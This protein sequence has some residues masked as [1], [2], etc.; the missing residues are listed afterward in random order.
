[1]GKVDFYFNSMIE[2]LKDKKMKKTIA[3]FWH[4]DF[5]DY[6]T[7]LNSI[8]EKIDSGNAPGKYLKQLLLL[9]EKIISKAGSLENKIKNYTILEKI[10]RNFRGAC[11]PI[12]YRSIILKRAYEKPC[13]YPGDWKMLEMIYDNVPVSSGIGSLI[14]RYF[15]L[16]PYTKAVRNRKDKIKNIL[17]EYIRGLTEREANILNIAC[18]SCR[19]IREIIKAEPQIFRNKHIVLS[20]VDQDKRA[21]KFS[22][23]EIAKLKIKTFPH[24]ILQYFINEQKYKK[25]LGK[26]NLVYSIGLADYLPDGLLKK[27]INFLF[28]LL[29]EGGR[30]IIAHKDIDEYKPVSPDWWCN[31]KF[32][33]RNEQKFIELI[34]GSNISNYKISICR[35]KSRVIFFATIRK[36]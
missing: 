11:S 33:P 12:I 26:Q 36:R 28:S 3:A 27:M 13:G 5:K 7:R 30:L 25:S 16:N 10:K 17:T 23:E 21:L 2:G 15:L 29:K 31:W 1:M 24:N 20:L 35:E 22:R 14:D 18:G 9:N 4:N 32:F 19:E 34:K 8:A 6:L